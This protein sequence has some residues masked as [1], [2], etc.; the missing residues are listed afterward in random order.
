MAKPHGARGAW[1][2][3]VLPDTTIIARS[4]RGPR[5]LRLSGGAQLGAAAAL[6]ALLI[7]SLASGVLL[8][9][10]ALDAEE[11]RAALDL[12][13]AALEAELAARDG[14]VRA[15][16]RA[17]AS[18]RAAVA[19][20]DARH[21]AATA[22]A[23]ER[24]A[25]SAMR[26][27][28]AAEIEEL[29]AAHQAAAAARDGFEARLREVE[30]QRDLAV[31]DRNEIAATL[32]RVAIAL[33]ATATARD[34]AVATASEIETALGDLE[35]SMEA[36]RDR[37]TRILAQ[38]EQAAELSIGSLEGM[39]NAAGV[40]VD[41]LIENLRREQSGAG[42]PFI[43]ARAAAE[44]LALPEGA[45]VL[46]VISDLERVNLLRIAATRMPF[47]APV[48]S[49]HFTSKF[50]NRRDPINGRHGFH[51][52]VDM[53]DRRGTPI[54]ASAEGEVVFAGRQRGY[55]R[56]VKVRHAFGFET[57]YAH[58]NKIRVK[59]GQRVSRGARIGDMGNTGRS[60]GTHLHYE[61]R[62]NGEPVDPMKFIKAG[63]HVDVL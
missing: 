12:R 27:A 26:E 7:W 2:E 45:R 24:D 63:R 44:T 9:K 39:L 22:L 46:S 52:G 30:G 40:N 42:G 57:V 51:S 53:S 13:I 11:T 1:L 19:A 8:G 17:E 47:G 31:R 15:A 3:R 5:Y 18:A 37:Q 29:A 38:I 25:L 54:Y 59:V 33:N 14:A 49:P 16:E 32:E 50:G 55:G 61:V 48:D 41:S 23:A 20:L 6:S 21:D 28:S 10:T 4:R 58:M 34:D 36:E 35:H 62:V 56:I 43:P 60:T